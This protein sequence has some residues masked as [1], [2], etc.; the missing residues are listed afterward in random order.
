MSGAHAGRSIHVIAVQNRWA[1]CYYETAAESVE[2]R[3]RFAAWL[4]IS[5]GR[6][7]YIAMNNFLG[8]R[9]RTGQDTR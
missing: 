6:T 1:V 7:G 4:F 2:V 5:E 8:F 3:G 9:L